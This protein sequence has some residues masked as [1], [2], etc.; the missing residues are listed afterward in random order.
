MFNIDMLCGAGGVSEGI[1]WAFGRS[2]DIAIDHKPNAV[3]PH[4]VRALARAQFPES[5]PLK[6]LDSESPKPT[7]K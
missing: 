1:Q 7:P 3:V 6:E 2:P 4:V 5:S